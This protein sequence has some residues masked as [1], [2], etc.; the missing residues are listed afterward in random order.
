MDLVCPP[1]FWVII[2]NTCQYVLNDFFLG[3]EILGIA[4]AHMSLGTLQDAVVLVAFMV[5]ISLVFPD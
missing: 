5:G 1:C 2:G 4:K 3:K